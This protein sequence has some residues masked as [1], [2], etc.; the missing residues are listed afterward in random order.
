M[1]INQILS[2]LAGKLACISGQSFVDCTA[3]QGSSPD[4]ISEV[5]A[6]EGF[7]RHG[8]ETLYNG[9]T[10]HPINAQIFMG[11]TYY[12]RLKHM[13][14]DKNHCLT[15]EHEILTKSGWKNYEQLCTEDLIATRNAAGEL[16]YQKP[17]EIFY[18]P[19]FQ[20]QMIE[21][22]T[23]DFSLKTTDNH[24]MFAC[25]EHSSHFTHI[26]ARDIIHKTATYTCY[27]RNVNKDYQLMLKNKK[28][29]YKCHMSA[30]LS[31]LAVY[32]K[33]GLTT[34][35][36][37][38]LPSFAFVK[39]GL[40]LLNWEYEVHD[41][42]IRVYREKHVCLFDHLVESRGWPDWVT[43]CSETQS[44][45]LVDLV[46]AYEHFQEEQVDI[47]GRIC[48]QAGWSYK[49]EITEQGLY[50]VK[51]HEQTCYKVVKGYNLTNT[52]CP[53][54]CIQV[55]NETFITRKGPFGAPILT[56][57]SRK[58]G[59][60]QSL[61]KQPVEGRSRAGGLRFG[62]M[63]RD[64]VI[65][66]SASAILREKLFL[67]SDKYSVPVCLKCGMIG[68]PGKT[69]CKACPAEKLVEVQLPYASKLLLFEL[70]SMNIACR[71]KVKEGAQE[72]EVVATT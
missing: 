50:S 67:L 44:Q 34:E 40:T 18:Y 56:G 51:K 7:N 57:N 15:M 68:H 62:E 3:F 17:L 53:V 28:A 36:W 59:K 71:I 10:G 29:A 11:I 16:E 33:D 47:F 49:K 41:C 38:E 37:I 52:T 14:A 21:I 46:G 70:N 13:V 61:T 27:A 43:E 58:Q 4:A 20:G 12:Q 65:S 26:Y 63:E 48:L 39:T 35:T 31:I 54:Y 42:R 19:D 6:K 8:W 22:T 64:A 30:L 24:R 55:P 2:T 60:V 66:H 23:P 45:Q 25:E 1:T 72:Y 5:L 9:T 32:M 69:R